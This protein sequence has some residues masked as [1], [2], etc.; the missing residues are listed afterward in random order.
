[1]GFDIATIIDLSFALQVKALKEAQVSCAD[2]TELSQENVFHF[3]K[4]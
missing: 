1:M 3:P 2:F 4:L